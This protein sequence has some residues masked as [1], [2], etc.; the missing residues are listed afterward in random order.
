MEEIH[1]SFQN[2]HKRIH[3]FFVGP[4]QTFMSDRLVFSLG[5][6]WSSGT[7]HSTRVSIHYQ[8]N[9]YRTMVCSTHD[10]VTIKSMINFTS[11]LHVHFLYNFITSYEIIH[12]TSRKTKPDVTTSWRKLICEMSE[13]IFFGAV[14]E[15]VQIWRD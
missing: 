10:S 6:A 13:G 1:I 8:K 5:R 9:V 7:G 3:Y 4:K 2:H 11:I 15:C 12:K 14:W